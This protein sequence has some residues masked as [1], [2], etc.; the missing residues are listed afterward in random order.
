MT[1][2]DNTNR[3]TLFVNDRKSS[4]SQPDLRGKINIGGVDH[5]LSGWWKEPRNGGAQFLS[6]SLGD[7]VQQ[8]SA[9]PAHFRQTAPAR[10]EAPVRRAPPQRMPPPA[11]D[12]YDAMDPTIPF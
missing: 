2:Y 6:L 5:W 11:D 9:A 8:Q 4:D 10:Q 3:G 1:Q 7:E 12:G